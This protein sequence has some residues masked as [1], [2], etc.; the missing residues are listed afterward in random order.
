MEKF[1]KTSVKMPKSRSKY[2]MQFLKNK[3]G[4][5]DSHS[6]GVDSDVQGSYRQVYSH[7]QPHLNK[8]ESKSNKHIVYNSHEHDA[9]MD[10]SNEEMKYTTPTNVSSRRRIKKVDQYEE[11]MNSS[12]QKYGIQS[13]AFTSGTPG[14]CVLGLTKTKSKSK[15][16]NRLPF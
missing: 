12:P 8:P 2:L 9:H 4:S 15:G 7:V 6:P 16:K 5:T 13:T 10:D 3:D 14:T 11:Y 1:S